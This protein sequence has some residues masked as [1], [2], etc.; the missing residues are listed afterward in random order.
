MR[1]ITEKEVKEPSPI[2]Y[3]FQSPLVS[4][5]DYNKIIFFLNEKQNLQ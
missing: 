1:M 3:Y 4:D 5:W 2:K